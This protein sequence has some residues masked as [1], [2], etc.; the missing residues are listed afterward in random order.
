MRALAWALPA[1]LLAGCGK[2]VPKPI[3]RLQSALRGLHGQAPC[4]SRI[5]MEWPASWPVPVGGE[6]FKTFFYP[7]GRPGAPLLAAPMGE[8]EFD[9]SGKPSVCRRL[10]GPLKELS[11]PRW[12]T[13]AAAMKTE[14]FQARAAELYAA[15]EEVA[16]LFAAG[17]PLAPEQKRKA[18][19]YARLFDLLAEPAL[20]PYYRDLSPSFWEWLAKS[21]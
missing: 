7:I 9:L 2:P 18:A 21:P 3:P 15:T 17:K 4:D 16:A 10:A 13:Q 12:G 14:E 1:L 20:K 19:A 11:G 8:A 6:V 5:P